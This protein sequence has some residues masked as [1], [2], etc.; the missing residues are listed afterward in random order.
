[1]ALSY[2][3]PDPL[4]RH[5]ARTE[6]ATKT[7]KGRDYWDIEDA[8]SAYRHVAEQNGFE[9]Y[10]EWLMAG[11]AAKAEFGDAGLE[12]WRIA[13]NSTVTPAVEACKWNSFSNDRPNGVALESVLMLA[14]RLGWKGRVRQSVQSMFA[15][16]RETTIA[17]GL[18]PET[19]VPA[20][21]Q[22]NESEVALLPVFDAPSL[23]GVPVPERQWLVPGLIPACQVT[24]LN[25]DGGTGKSLLTLQLL[26]ST[27]IGR[28]WI[29]RPVT[30]G[31]A[32][33]LT[34]EDD[35]DEVHRRLADIVRESGIRFED[36]QGLNI[37]SLAGADAILAAPESRSN[38][39]L[40]T[41]LFAALNDL[42]ADMRPAIVA[43]DTLA[44]LFG[45]EEN[46]RTQSRQ[47]IGLLR[48]IALR[49]RT[50]VLLLAHPSLSGMA[51][52][53]G[54]S[55][56]TGWN[57]SLRS[58][59]YFERIRGQEGIEPDPDARVLRAVKNN[60][61][62]V[63]EEILVH[64]RGGVFVPDSVSPESLLAGHDANARA[65]RVFLKMMAIFVAEHRGAVSH[66]PGS[67]YAPKLFADDMRAE[68]IRTKA[69]KFAMDRLIAAKRIET[70]IEGP[71]SRLRFSLII[72]PAAK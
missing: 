58:R 13:H 17:S 63:G 43:L 66:R 8:K 3:A 62:R 65:E 7:S 40:T 1:M 37:C 15:G 39:L 6:R 41:P 46:Q 36:L 12:V 32:L 26:V 57:N 69:L 48:R 38:I 29:G 5:C 10:E 31:P 4:V 53:T 23:A 52:G 44:D 19:P 42:I 34:A 59:L 14:R 68:G 35:R 16:V 70:V 49:H 9:A 22:D 27:V 2:P 72:S 33:F 18:P 50:T 61:G 55:G 28:P 47:F 56:S 21:F 54:A 51:S 64:W 45:G 20:P 30:Q 71:P 60:Y 11:M 25:G 67:N 24:G